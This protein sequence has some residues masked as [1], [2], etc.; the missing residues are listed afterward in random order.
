MTEKYIK[1][2]S[3]EKVKLRQ[4]LNNKQSADLS[5]VIRGE[6]FLQMEIYD[7]LSILDR[8]RYT[9]IILEEYDDQSKRY[10][11]EAERVPTD[12]YYYE[13]V[14]MEVAEDCTLII[15]YRERERKIQ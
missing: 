4:S 12:F 2:G 1:P 11:F 13:A 3:L 9:T 7:L 14:S 5:A 8:K 6:R 10:I 15:Y